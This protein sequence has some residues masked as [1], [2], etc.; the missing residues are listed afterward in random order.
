MYFSTPGAGLCDE[1]RGKT[2]NY[3][4]NRDTELFNTGTSFLTVLNVKKKKK[5]NEIPPLKTNW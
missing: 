5:I 1:M 2:H 4:N 3:V